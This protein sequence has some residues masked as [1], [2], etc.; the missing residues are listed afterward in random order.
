MIERYTITFIIF[1]RLEFFTVQDTNYLS[2]K[3]LER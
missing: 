1:D 3:P 2:P